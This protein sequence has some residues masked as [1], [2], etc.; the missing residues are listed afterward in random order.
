MKANEIFEGGRFAVIIGDGFSSRDLAVRLSVFSDI[1]CVICDSRRSAASLLAPSCAF[2]KLPS[3]DCVETLELCLND[4]YL[5]SEEGM[6]FIIF[7]SKKYRK[8]Q[9]ELEEKLDSKFI[10]ANSRTIFSYSARANLKSV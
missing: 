5:C 8:L 7:N 4:I 10:F 6:K 1:P 2:F 9:N 3:S